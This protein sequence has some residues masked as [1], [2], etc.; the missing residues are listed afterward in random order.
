[1]KFLT[2]VF[3]PLSPFIPTS[4]FINFGDFCQFPHLLHPSLLLFWQKFASLTVY[5]ALAFY[6]KLESTRITYAP[7]ILLWQCSCYR[8]ENQN[9]ESFF[10]YDANLTLVITMELKFIFFLSSIGSSVK[11]H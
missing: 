7:G 5:S 4:P 8:N 11:R 9:P 6:L 3:L 10:N 2:D 1:M